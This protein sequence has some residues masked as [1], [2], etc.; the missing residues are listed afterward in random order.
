MKQNDQ[1]I[2]KAKPHEKPYKLADGKGLYLLITP[3]GG[4]Y[5]RLDYNMK[6]R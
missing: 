1:Q 4:K 3:T 2:K 6:V 5:W